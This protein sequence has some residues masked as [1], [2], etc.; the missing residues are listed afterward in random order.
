MHFQYKKLQNLKHSFN[1]QLSETINARL[2]LVELL[3]NS[4]AIARDP[5]SLS[6]FFQSK[7]NKIFIALEVKK[8]WKENQVENFKNIVN[9]QKL[10]TFFLHR[11]MMFVCLL[12]CLFRTN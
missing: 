9:T 3:A 8:E 7:L 10:N 2:L 1:L 6:N 12:T 5:I 4:L 11:F